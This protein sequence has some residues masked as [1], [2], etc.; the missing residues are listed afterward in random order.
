MPRLNPAPEFDVATWLNTPQPI[1][2]ASL[3]GKVVLIEAFQMLCP[4]CVEHGLPQAARVRAAFPTSEVAVIGLHTVF[5]HHEAQGTVAALKAFL[6][7]YRIGFPV[8]I[9]QPSVHGAA[10][11]TMTAYQM[12]GTPTLILIDRLGR[13]RA[14]HFGHVTDLRLGAEIQALIGET[15]PAP[16]TAPATTTL[17]AVCTQEGCTV[18]SL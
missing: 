18:P 5:E 1:T 13:L 6:H 16:A 14:Q 10:P 2:L 8:G 9:D 3:A 7:E 12:Q 11:R 4:G 17:D 15:V